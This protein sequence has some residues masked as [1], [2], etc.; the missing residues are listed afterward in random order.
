M[1]SASNNSIEPDELWESLD[2]QGSVIDRLILH[3]VAR[4]RVDGF[5]PDP[6]WSESDDEDI[7]EDD[8]EPG[9]QENDVSYSI[10]E[11]EQM[12]PQFRSQTTSLLD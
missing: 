12:R 6:N 2:L 1:T 5:D 11:E 9:G 3:S 7:D 4:R 10:N 8:G